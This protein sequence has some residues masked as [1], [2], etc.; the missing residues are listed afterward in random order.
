MY[1]DSSDTC[2]ELSFQLGNN[3]IGKPNLQYKVS[4]LGVDSSKVGW[5]FVSSKYSKWRP[6]ERMSAGKQSLDQGPCWNVF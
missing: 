2:N 3:P 4:P 6:L 5:I 1:V